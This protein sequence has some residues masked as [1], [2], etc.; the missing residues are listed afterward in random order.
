MGARMMKYCPLSGLTLFITLVLVSCSES[1][2]QQ[3][4]GRWY[5]ESQL[6]TGSLVFSQNCA[7]CHGAQ[8]EGTVSDWK[9]RLDDGSLPPPPLNGSAHAWHHPQSVLLQVI[10]SGGAPFGGNMPAFADQLD[11][12][13][14]L[15]VIAYFQSFWSDEVYAQWTQMGGT[16]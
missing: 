10:D 2:Q 13:E 1:E 3:V 11:E 8:A 12:S 9:Q 15:A 4:T 7:Q 6:T 14:K 5:S 16:N